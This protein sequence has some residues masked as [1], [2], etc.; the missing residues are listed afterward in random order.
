MPE[1]K[2]EET[3]APPVED[4][5]AF[6]EDRPVVVEEPKTAPVPKKKPETKFLVEELL[7]LS[8]EIAGVPRYM[9]VGAMSHGKV[10]SDD[11]I[12]RKEFIDHCEA[13]KKVKAFG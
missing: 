1:K 4:A 5:S 10:R 9:A 3:K 12:T 13:F 8:Q 11:R 7:G 2:V 6:V